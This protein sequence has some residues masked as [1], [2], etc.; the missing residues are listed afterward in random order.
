[1]N[2]KK[3]IFIFN[4]SLVIASGDS[5]LRTESRFGAEV[6]KIFRLRLGVGFI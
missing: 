5:A 6:F 2:V 1:M 4:G 3:F